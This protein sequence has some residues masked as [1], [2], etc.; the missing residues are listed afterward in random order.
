MP[1]LGLTQTEGTLLRW[2]KNEGEP[3]LIGEPL[4]EIETDKVTV[5][6]ES[7]AAGVLGR[8]LLTEGGTAAIGRQ[9]AWI[10]RPDEP[11]PAA[12]MPRPEVPPST[13]PLAP[14]SA[15][16]GESVLSPGAAGGAPPPSSPAARRL[17]RELGVDLVVVRGSGPGG[18]ILE[19][20]IR[21]AATT[22]ARPPTLGDGR[23]IEL[24]HPRQVAA[25]RL[26]ES[27]QAVPHFYLQ[28]VIDASALVAQKQELEPQH[29]TYTDLFVHAVAHALSQHPMVNA[30][31]DDGAVWQYAGIAIGLAVHTDR[32]LLVPVL[33]DPER[34]SVLELARL[35]RGLVERTLAGKLTPQDLDG[36]TFTI[37]NLGMHRVDSAWPVINPPQAAILAVGAVAPRVLAVEGSA[38]VRPTVEL[39]LAVDHRVMDGVEAAAFLDTLRG[40]LERADS[41][42]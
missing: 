9:I 4:C 7:P 8:R 20:D 35:R 32:G 6:L 26:S 30:R 29:V 41:A 3:V 42:A 33:R 40:E 24:T 34:V 12:A 38:A 25:R 21:T 11:V 31:W 37:T 39:V 22:A 1:Q 28:V 13:R 36:C 27:F 18:R 10:V 15:A 5:D 17:A 19:G 23:R 2:Y 16:Q 14:A